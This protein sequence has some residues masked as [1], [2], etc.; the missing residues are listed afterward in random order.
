VIIGIS[1]VDHISLWAHLLRRKELTII[2]SRRS[3]F[4]LTPAIRMMAAGLIRPEEIVTHR[5]P[6]ERLA[7]GMDL[8]HEVRDGVLKAMVVI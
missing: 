2:M 6:L 1:A 7:E 8:V 3:N 5:F 4:A